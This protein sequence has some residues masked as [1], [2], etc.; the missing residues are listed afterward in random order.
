MLDEII[1]SD[2]Q[3]AEYIPLAG[4]KFRRLPAF[5]EK[6]HAIVNVKNEDTRCFGY[7]LLSAL[8]LRA[9]DPQ[10]PFWYKRFFAKEG[11]DQIP[12]AVTHDQ[13]PAIEDKLKVCI[14][15]FSFWDD[16]GKARTPVYHSTKLYPNTI[17]LLY[18]ETGGTV[19]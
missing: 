4:L 10:R 18:W 8:H 1:N 14:N 5:L 7:S 9:K 16:E 17:D 11:L 12:C 6:K 2:L 19:V 15:L 13:I 3:V